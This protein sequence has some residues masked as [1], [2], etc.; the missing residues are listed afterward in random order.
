MGTTTTG[1]TVNPQPRDADEL[2]KVLRFIEEHEGHHGAPESALFLTGANTRDRVELTGQLHEILKR[3][4][5]ALSS[6]QSI[7][8][9]AGDEVIS[10]QQAAD[11]LGLSRPTVVRLIEEGELPA[12]VPGAVRRRLHVADVLAYRDELHQR[13]NNFI[14]ESSA[15]F[16]DIE[17]N[18][19]ADLLAE[20]RR[21]A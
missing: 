8:L 1:T 3:I 9:L 6:G 21:K 4:T 14:A 11:L 5:Q 2:A 12:H 15:Q 17:E 18:E 19:V 16:G 13:R 20:A 7:S 10:T